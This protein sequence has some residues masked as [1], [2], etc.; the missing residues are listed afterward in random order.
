MQ[1]EKGFSLI[2]L[3]IVISI[4][5]I[6][7]GIAYTY[8]DK[9]K[10]VSKSDAMKLYNIISKAKSE[11]VKRNR[12]LYVGINNK[13]VD[14]YINNQ[15]VDSYYLD[16]FDIYT[17]SVIGGE[18][19]GGQIPNIQTCGTNGTLPTNVC[20]DCSGP[21]PGCTAYDNWR[22]SFYGK[23]YEYIYS[24]NNLGITNKEIKLKLKV[25]NELLNTLNINFIGTIET[26]LY[27]E[28]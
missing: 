17:D 10:Y 18:L 28:N 5:G 22:Q 1:N 13:N 26:V 11:A 12:L 24:F 23:Q 20:N 16:Y 4:I 21:V 9:K 6:L 27:S 14:F 3:L 2:E 15:L 7:S 8:F 19:G 25:D